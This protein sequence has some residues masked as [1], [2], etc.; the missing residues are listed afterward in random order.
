[1][2]KENTLPNFRHSLAIFNSFTKIVCQ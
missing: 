1:M 2:V